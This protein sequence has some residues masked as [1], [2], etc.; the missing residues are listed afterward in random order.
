MFIYW[1]NLGPKIGPLGVTGMAGVTIDRNE[2]II[3]KNIESNVYAHRNRF[4]R[5]VCVY[6]NCIKKLRKSRIGA[7]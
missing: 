7:K 5:C 4:S 2:E 6:L 1:L 3:N